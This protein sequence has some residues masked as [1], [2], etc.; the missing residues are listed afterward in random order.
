MQSAYAIGMSLRDGF[1]LVEIMITI[2][3]MAILMAVGTVSISGLQAQARDKERQT[4][5][6]TIARGLEQRYQN[7]NPYIKDNSADLLDKG[8][9]PSVAEYHHM[10][11]ETVIDWGI[12]F[13]P[14]PAPQN[15]RTEVLVGTTIESFK[16]PSGTDGFILECDAY[17][18]CGAAGNTSRLNSRFSSSPDAYIYS[19]KDTSGET[20]YWENC[21]GYDLYWKSENGTI[22]KIASKHQ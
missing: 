3:I 18:G 13:D 22:R 14:N 1:T 11:G 16:G 9:Y 20:C 6:E 15:N 12:V 10:K 7:G 4:D 2:T 21:V 19:P 17:S 8:Q 5:V